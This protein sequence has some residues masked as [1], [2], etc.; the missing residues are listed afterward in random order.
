MKKNQNGTWSLF[1]ITRAS[2]E[3]IGNDLQ[4]LESRKIAA[5]GSL[6]RHSLVL[7][8]SLEGGTTHTQRAVNPKLFIQV[9][10]V[11]INR[12]AVK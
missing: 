12:I 1:L 10:Q 11:G 6:Q 2:L 8:R 3:S 7:L 5:S 4:L 9:A